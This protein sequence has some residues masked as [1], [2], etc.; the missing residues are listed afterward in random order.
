MYL[1]TGERY[2][3]FTA[4]LSYSF[5]F[6]LQNICDQQERNHNENHCGF[7][8]QEYIDMQPK[9]MS[10]VKIT[11]RMLC[12]GKFNHQHWIYPI[13]TVFLIFRLGCESPT[14][15]NKTRWDDGSSSCTCSSELMLYMN[16][17]QGP[18][19]MWWIFSGSSR[20]NQQVGDTRGTR[21]LEA[22]RNNCSCWN[23]CRQPER[24]AGSRWFFLRVMTSDGACVWWGEDGG[25]K[26]EQGK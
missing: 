9:Y 10:L 26:P 4:L 13:I 14:R 20:F 5:A 16:C 12:W 6:F 2:L 8:I 11:F 17:D 7:V 24:S 18:P 19:V 22:T 15:M 21:R 25:R 23:R 1:V 3:R